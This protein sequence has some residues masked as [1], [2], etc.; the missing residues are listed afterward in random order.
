MY[1]YYTVHSSDS[2][3]HKLLILFTLLN[4]LEPE[5]DVSFI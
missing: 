2:T 5:A 1:V 3:V 4:W